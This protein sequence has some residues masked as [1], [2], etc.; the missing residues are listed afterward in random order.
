[1][2]VMVAAALYAVWFLSGRFSRFLP[3]STRDKYGRVRSRL[4]GLIPVLPLIV[5]AILDPINGVVVIVHVMLIW[6]I[7]DGI[8]HLVR[9]LLNRS[10]K[11]GEE[12]A[13][14]GKRSKPWWDRFYIAGACAV[15]FC[16]VYLS[17]GWYLAHHVSE[18]DYVLTTN[19]D[20]GVDSIRV[21]QIAD[22]HVGATFDGEGFADHMK[23]I[24]KVNPDVLV[25]TGDYVD[26]DTSKEDMVRS[27]KALGE[28]KTTYGVFFVYGN[29]DK[30][31]FDYRDFDD[32]DLRA[33]LTK[34][35]VKILEDTSVDITDGI[36]LIGRKDRS[37]DQRADGTGRMGMS[38]LTADM[39]KDKYNILLDH[40][41]NDYDNEAASGVDLVLSGHT[42]GGQL[43]PIGWIGEWSGTNDK[44]YG[45]ETR[46]DTTFIVNSGISD[47]AIGYKTGTSSEFGVIDIKRG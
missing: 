45:L 2:I 27:C 14:E 31:Y 46:E 37:E 42:H 8:G 25:I 16:V 18:T 12:A 44:T 6:L 23:T 35:G 9:K 15:V 29:H 24:Q 7:A 30:G 47:W 21:V 17:C 19:K 36:C 33:E 40:Q 3:K 34:N 10:S 43:I 4:L 39:D 1:M 11:A 41:P 38:E 32:A 28:L 26:D 22:S 20:I 13:G 5:Y